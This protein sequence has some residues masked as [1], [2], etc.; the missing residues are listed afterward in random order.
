MFK[1]LPTLSPTA[2]KNFEKCPLAFRL[3]KIDKILFPPSLPALKGILAHKILEN[4]YKTQP[5]N[6]TLNYAKSTIKDCWNSIIENDIKK[7]NKQ[8][9]QSIQTDQAFFDEVEQFII[10]YFS[11]ENP[12]NVLVDSQEQWIDISTKE[13]RFL[14]QIDRVDKSK[15]G[16]IRIVDYKTGKSPNPRFL[17]EVI[18]QL[19]FYAY[20]WLKNYKFLPAQL[21]LL[22]LKDG[23]AI[24]T[25]PSQNDALNLEKSINQIWQNIKSTA[26]N[27]QWLPRKNPLCDWCEF[28]TQYCPIFGGTL[29]TLEPKKV[30]LAI[31]VNPNV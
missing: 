3:N 9:L 16:S 23:K 10:T 26:K 30:K 31:G 2:A 8:N 11:M 1:R 27:N 19:H 22:Y 17:E 6:R 7:T 18:F 24:Q 4:I 14:G 29:P 21:S 12:Q 28:K 15:Q 25:K 13:V 5:Q 20:L